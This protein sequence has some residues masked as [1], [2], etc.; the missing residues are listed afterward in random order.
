V[1]YTNGQD[2]HALVAK[3]I[4]LSLRRLLGHNICAESGE[5]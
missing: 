1:H 2:A 4:P 3:A 5:K